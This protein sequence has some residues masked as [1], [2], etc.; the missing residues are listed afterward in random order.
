[1][2]PVG[3]C[4][5]DETGHIGNRKADAFEVALDGH[6][7]DRA[8]VSAGTRDGAAIVGEC[9]FTHVP[10][11]LHIH[12]DS[13]D[14]GEGTG[15]PAGIGCR[16]RGDDQHA[17]MCREFH[18][19]L[20]RDF[21]FRIDGTQTQVDNLRLLLA[22]PLQGRNKCVPCGAQRT[23]EHFDA[24]QV[25][26]RSLFTEHSRDRRPMTE[27]IDIVVAAMSSGIDCNA[28]RHSLHVWMG[29]VDAAI[30]DDDLRPRFC[31]DKVTTVKHE[32]Q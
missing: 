31:P 5:R 8:R 25:R 6:S 23:V 29:G 1:M 9:N 3:P 13:D 7:R 19:P 2:P 21:A 11:Q 15:Q 4:A 16:R 12:F 14:A 24:Q 26:C 32:F 27:S 10:R 18:F 30:D 17:L 20:E 22:C 28:G